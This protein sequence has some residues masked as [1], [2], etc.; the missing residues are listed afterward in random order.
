MIENNYV[1]LL[2]ISGLNFADGLHRCTTHPLSNNLMRMNTFI[3]LNHRFIRKGSHRKPIGLIDVKIVSR[4]SYC[5]L[6][7]KI[8]GCHIAKLVAIINSIQ[9]F[10]CKYSG[11]QIITSFFPFSIVLFCVFSLFF[12]SIPYCSNELAFKLDLTHRNILL[13]DKF[14]FS[15][16]NYMC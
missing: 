14:I 2:S 6:M 12:S 3:K 5:V 10:S 1:H 4:H 16:W 11:W 15:K 9:S 7:G 8:H 13:A